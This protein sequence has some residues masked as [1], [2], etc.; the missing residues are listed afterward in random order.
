MSK[1]TRRRLMVL[2][3]VA[4]VVIGGL[5]FANRSAI[6]TGIDQILG[7]DYQGEGYSSVLLE[8]SPGDTGES[9][10]NS[11]V[12]LGVV[13]NFRT[14]YKLILEENPKFYPGT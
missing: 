13:K 5:A 10:A 9:I 4:L 2:I 8:V 12:D 1:F 6:R 3:A 11:L 14:V 7:N